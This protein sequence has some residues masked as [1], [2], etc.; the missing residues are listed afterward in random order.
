MRAIVKYPDPALS[1]PAADATLFG[2]IY[3]RMLVEE[4]FE[5]MYAAHGLGLAA[6][7]VGIP[8]RIAVIDITFK[9]NPDAKLV[10][11]NPAIVNQDGKQRHSE[12]CL[13][14]P[15]FR[16]EVTR[17]NKV[18]VRAQDLEGRTFERTVEDLLARALLHE[19]DHLNGQLI[20]RFSDGWLKTEAE[21]AG[22]A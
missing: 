2:S 8:L 5:S 4:M 16:A 21:R 11:M 13:S 12:G 10:L 17:A 19:I 6:P 22:K 15:D 18:T 14:L 3:L 1:Q 9:E 20:S 7:Q